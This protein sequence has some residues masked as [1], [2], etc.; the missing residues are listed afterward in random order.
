MIKTFESHASYEEDI[1][2]YYTQAILGY[3]DEL[4]TILFDLIAEEG[5]V[6]DLEHINDAEFEAQD[7]E[8]LI[9]DISEEDKEGLINFDD[10]IVNKFNDFDFKLKE[11]QMPDYPTSVDFIDYEKGVVYI[12][13]LI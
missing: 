3:Y 4:T 10:E 11:S 5:F 9:L 7:F 13:R 8:Y 6:E 2:K 1:E 12:I